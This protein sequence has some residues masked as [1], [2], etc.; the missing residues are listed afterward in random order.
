[1]ILPYP[2]KLTEYYHLIT[3]GMC[4]VEVSKALPNKVNTRIYDYLNP[5]INRDA[6][7]VIFDLGKALAHLQNSG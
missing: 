2:K 1:M 3:I 5:K 6:Q 7:Q 4:F